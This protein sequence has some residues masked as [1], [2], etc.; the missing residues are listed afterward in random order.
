M[1]IKR[2]QKLIYM[3]IWLKKMND[4]YLI[5]IVSNYFF[6]K[7]ICQK[8]CIILQMSGVTFY[9]MHQ[10]TV[11]RQHCVNICS[12]YYSLKIFI[13][14]QLHRIM[15]ILDQDVKIYMCLR[16][17]MNSNNKHKRYLITINILKMYLAIVLCLMTLMKL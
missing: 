13:Y 12:I 17:K 15:M 11:V 9:Y 7:Q 5:K 8:N 1:R 16:P 4:D 3:R 2:N 14:L 10:Q 6:Y